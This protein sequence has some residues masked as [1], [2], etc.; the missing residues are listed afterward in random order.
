MIR[1]NKAAGMVVA[2]ALCMGF[3]ALGSPAGGVTAAPVRA[4]AYIRAD[5]GL[6]TF[7]PDV[8]PGSNCATPDQ[9]DVQQVSDA[10]SVARNVHVDA[11]LFSSGAAGGAT[12]SDVDVPATYELFG[13]GTI[14]ACP[15][16][17][18]PNGP[19]TAVRHDHNGD[20]TFEHCHQ[21]GYQA[22]QAAGNFEYHA[23]VN[24]SAQPGQSRVLFCADSDQD[25]CL[26]ERVLTQVGVGWTSPR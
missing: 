22:T 10:G 16:P 14:N 3:L 8:N 7:N 24:S 23:R 20:G 9:A 18:G 5:I 21:S 11:C 6:A 26:D 4:Q 19:K 17:D 1:R 12:Q 13:V 15:D 25:G 2:T